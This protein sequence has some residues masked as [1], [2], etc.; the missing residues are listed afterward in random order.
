MR[1]E[2]LTIGDELLDGLITDTN[3]AWLGGEL[4]QRGIPIAQHLTLRDELSALVS[5]FQAIAA[6]ADV[7]ITSGGLGPTL[8]DLTI[9]ALAT[10]AQVDMTDDPKVWARIQQ[11]YGDRPIP[12]TNRRQIRVPDGGRALYSEVGTAPGIELTIGKCTFYCVPGVP[13]EMR[14]H[15]QKYILPALLAR[16]TAPP[17]HARTLRFSLLGESTLAELVDQLDL[18]KSVLVSYRTRMVENQVRLRSTDRAALDQAAEAVRAVGQKYYVGQ[19][20]V[21]LP[22]ALIA[23]ATKRR[24]MLG[25]AESCTG[26]LLGATLTEVSGASAAF[27]GSIVSYANA[28][29]HGVLGVSHQTLAEDGAVSEACAIQMAK[30]AREALGCD[31][32]VSITGIAGPGGGTP[33]KPVGTVCFGW[34]GEGM[35]QVLTRR[36]RGNRDQV[37]QFSV[38]YALDRILRHLNDR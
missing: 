21:G 2:L 3:A 15:T 34:S 14:W 33:E 17:L 24:L 18:P 9:E 30:G 20:S 1:I 22:E 10:A 31:I 25:A 27:S 37:R 4:E 28:V 16:Q 8:D 19:D 32:A 6:R 7:C 12:D 13:R 29:K 36:F 11:I 23:A 5:A 35:D 26:G 38:A